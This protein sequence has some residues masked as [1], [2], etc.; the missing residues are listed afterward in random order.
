MTR[1]WLFIKLSDL[2]DLSDPIVRLS[3]N[4]WSHEGKI[5]YWKFRYRVLVI[6]NL[7]KEVLEEA[8]DTTSLQECVRS[9]M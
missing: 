8:L 5:K 4:C 9:L 7:L 6:V 3:K 1:K 2:S